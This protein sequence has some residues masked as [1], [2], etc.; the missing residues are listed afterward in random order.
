MLN[1]NIELLSSHRAAYALVN[2]VKY[3]LC[4]HYV[5]QDFCV[6]G[7]QLRVRR[8][9]RGD[10]AR[11]LVLVRNFPGDS[12]P[13]LFTTFSPSY[14]KSYFYRVVFNYNVLRRSIDLDS[15]NFRVLRRVIGLFAFDSGGLVVS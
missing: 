5:L 11:D 10:S 15:H 13:K 3:L 1:C 8:G 9:G 4:T 6:F 12:V 14:K 7:N 2:L